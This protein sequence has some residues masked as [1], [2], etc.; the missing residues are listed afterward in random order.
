M[1]AARYLVAA[2]AWIVAGYVSLWFAANTRIGPIVASVS[3]T[4]GIHQGDIVIVLAG[5]GVASLITVA[6]LRTPRH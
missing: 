2:A 5:I 3:H 4:H 6:A 1:R